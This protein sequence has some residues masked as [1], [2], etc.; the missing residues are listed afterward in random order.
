LACKKIA[1]TRLGPTGLEV[2]AMGFGTIPFGGKSWKKGASVDSEEGGRV[3]ARAF[4]LGINYWDTAEGYD[5]H[6]HIREGLTH[7]S[8]SDVVISTKSTRKTY[9]GAGTRIKKSLG[10]LDTS[11]IDIYFLHA[12]DS[13]SDLE[14][15]CSGALRR[16]RRA[17][18]NG[19]IRHIGLSTHRPE[20]VEA[21]SDVEDIEV[22]LAPVNKTGHL[23]SA[24]R[25]EDMISA[26]RKAYGAGKGIALMKI[27]AYGDLGLEE[28][29]EFSL[30][31]PSHTTLIGMRTSEELEEDAETFNRVWNRSRG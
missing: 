5:T 11:Y 18:D 9:E 20:V 1:K 6:R 31:I 29:L 7:V 21:A 19:L 10:E 2:S 3:L 28:G 15:R 12:V 23:P 4:E 26:I 8:R 30:G 24:C 27:F 22:I 25:L 14:R 16:M 17:R 13:V